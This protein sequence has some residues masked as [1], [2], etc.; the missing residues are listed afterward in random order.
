LA[1][2]ACSALILMVVGSF[3]VATWQR[4]RAE[5][6]LRAPN[7]GAVTGHQARA[8]AQKAANPGQPK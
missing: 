4:A 7:N 2:A 6:A 8:D 5:V 1:L 3:V